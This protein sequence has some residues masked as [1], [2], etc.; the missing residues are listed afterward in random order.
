MND[1]KNEINWHDA[2]NDASFRNELEKF[3]DHYMEEHEVSEEEI[4]AMFEDYFKFDEKNESIT[5][6]EK[7]FDS[8]KAV[9]TIAESNNNNESNEAQLSD[10][11]IDKATQSLRLMLLLL[12]MKDNGLE[13]DKNN[14]SGDK[15]K[16][17]KHKN[18]GNGV[19][20]AMLMSL[21]TG[22]PVQ[23][24]KNFI[25]TQTVGTKNIKDL[26]TKT[27]NLL[28]DLNMKIRIE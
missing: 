10:E 26:L 9:H 14:M 25:T 3:L 23:T 18:H 5:I 6:N 13:I 28:I 20:A 2:F 19:K 22:I 27:N 16:S 15:S 8:E 17:Q 21:I 12:L 24:C 1:K 11:D 7:S 4:D